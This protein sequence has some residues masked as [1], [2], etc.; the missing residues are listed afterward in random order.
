MSLAPWRLSRRRR[1]L[2]HHDSQQI[3]EAVAV[4]VGL[5]ADQVVGEHR[6]HQLAIVRQ[7]RD[8]RAV[9]PWG[10]QEEAD[11]PRDA[12]LAQIARERQEMIVVDPERRVG[13]AE[14]G[15]RARHIGVHRQI[16]AIIGF[17]DAREVGAVMQQRPQRRIR[18]AFVEAGIVLVG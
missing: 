2:K 4:R 7:V 1:R 17:G 6:L 14:G 9:G 11:L 10:V 12:E 18:I 13:P 3:G 15:E 5:E 8:G 16:G